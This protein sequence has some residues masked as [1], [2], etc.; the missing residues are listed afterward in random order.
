MTA[1]GLTYEQRYEECRHKI[2]AVIGEYPDVFGPEIEMPVVSNWVMVAAADDV[3]DAG[4]GAF[5]IMYPRGQW[6][7]ATLGL[8]E[9]AKTV[10]VA[11]RTSS[12]GD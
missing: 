3:G 11:R 7:Y 9:W 12:E 4:N 6:Y 8:F 2:E 10:I 1:E 5:Q